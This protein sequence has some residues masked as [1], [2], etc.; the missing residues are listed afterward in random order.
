[1]RRT[2]SLGTYAPPTPVAEK[3]GLEPEELP[4]IPNV[5]ARESVAAFDLA[6]EYA[7][8][9]GGVHNLTAWKDRTDRNGLVP[10]LIT[11][12]ELPLW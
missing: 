6:A 9:S 5:L 2:I 7:L 3:L 8:R 1:M 11:V 4:Y 10:S 12:D